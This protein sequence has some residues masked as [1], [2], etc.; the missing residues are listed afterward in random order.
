MNSGIENALTVSLIG[1][2]SRGYGTYGKIIKNM[3]NVKIAAV[4]EPDDIKRNKLSVEHNIP[5]NMQ[6]RSWEELLSK[7]KLTDGIIITNWIECMFNPPY[8]L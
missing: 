6:F 2:G 7:D 4:A 1:A 5:K 3:N 8:L